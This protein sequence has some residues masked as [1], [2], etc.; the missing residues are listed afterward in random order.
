MESLVVFLVLLKQIMWFSYLSLPLLAQMAKIRLQ[1]RDTGFEVL[2]FGR[3]IPLE[4]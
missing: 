1:C 3:K 2:E 4:M